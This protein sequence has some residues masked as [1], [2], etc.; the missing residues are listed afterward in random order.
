MVQ[1]AAMDILSGDSKAPG[2]KL[3]RLVMGACA[4][5]YSAVARLR[6]W[7]YRMGVLASHSAAAPVISIG[8]IT[9]GGTGKTPM[10]AW[11]AR[12]LMLVGRRPGIVLRGYKAVGG[13]SDEAELLA[14]L[15]KVKNEPNASQA[16]TEWT[17]PVIVDPNRV[18]GA[19]K[20][21]GQGADVIVLDDGFQHLRLRRD[22]NIVLIDA[23]NPFGYGYV[24]PRG[25]LREPV[26]VLQYA[27]AIVITRCDAIPPAG[28]EALRRKLASL[29]PRASIHTAVHAPTC[30]I[31]PTGEKKPL[32]VL[33]GKKIMAFCG[34]GNPEAF[35]STLGRLGA[36]PAGKI[37]FGD[38]VHYGPDQMEYIA[39]EAGLCGAEILVTTQK[40]RVKLTPAALAKPL[41]TLAVEIQFPASGDELMER[42]RQAMQGYEVEVRG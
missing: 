27:D 21:I 33:A 34:V 17:V 23:T 1:N 16:G 7:A 30:L 8:N 42:I 3:A 15:T 28:L 37:A 12:Q 9:T 13:R 18:R 20:A 6:R 22:L 39:R 38:H 35:F 41:W 26:S 29:A 36:V 24:L 25:L 31:D 32:D 4:V 5:P 11:V 2:A 14:G 10:V 40:D 19:G